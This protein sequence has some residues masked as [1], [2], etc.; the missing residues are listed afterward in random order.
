MST[1]EVTAAARSEAGRA[2]AVNED[3]HLMWVAPP[4]SR[5]AGGLRAVLAVADGRGGA[6]GGE[7]GAFAIGAVQAALCSDLETPPLPGL[8]DLENYLGELLVRINQQLAGLEPDAPAADAPTC[9]LTVVAV[10]DDGFALAH[11]GGGA[12][13][14]IRGTTLQPLTEA[15]QSALGAEAVVSVDVGIGD[16]RAG[17]RLVL[18][19]DGV[20]AHV[21][22]AEIARTV[23]QYDL[24]V[25]CDR[26]LSLPAE[27]DGMDNSTV[28]VGQVGPLEAISTAAQEQPN[29]MYSNPPGHSPGQSIREFAGRMGPRQWTIVAVVVVFCL[30]LGIVKAKHHGAAKDATALTPGAPTA[31]NPAPLPPTTT[32]PL[33]PVTPAA[34]ATGSLKVKLSLTAARQLVTLAVPADS[35]L[36]VTGLGKY[37]PKQVKAGWQF[38]LNSKAAGQSWRLEPAEAAKPADAKAADGKSGEAKAADAKSAAKKAEK[39]KAAGITGKLAEGKAALASLAP[40][41]Y[42]LLLGKGVEVAEIEVSGGS[43]E[44]AAAPA[45]DKAKPKGAKA[46]TTK[47]KPEA[48]VTKSTE[49]TH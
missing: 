7:G 4:G 12:A 11:V 47:P 28:V 9:A 23:G 38:E 34:K 18:C 30:M 35:T 44:G 32:P 29:L 40:G 16:L 25:A 20:T 45:E 36:T 24:Q 14:R 43:A 27:R 48:P 33:T 21:G 2:R 1:V 8:T 39:A 31:A 26:L 15:R 19:T 10:R 5:A 6:G 17:D 42:K 22:A 46:E 49:E 3:R 13:Y 37:Q 41:R